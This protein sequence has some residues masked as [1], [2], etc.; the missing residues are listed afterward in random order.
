MALSANIANNRS[1]LRCTAIQRSQRASYS[2]PTQTQ[3]SCS[4]SSQTAERS[5]TRRS[6]QTQSHVGVIRLHRTACSRR[7][8][9]NAITLTYGCGSQSP[10]PP[11]PHRT[12]SNPQLRR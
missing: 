2:R 9:E 12:C 10:S 7:A 5:S 3:R 11:S 1:G 4:C 8:Q 6:S